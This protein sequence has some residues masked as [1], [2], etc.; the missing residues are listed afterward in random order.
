MEYGPVLPKEEMKQ[1]VWLKAYENRNVDIALESGFALHAQ[2]GKG[3]WT[4]PDAMQKMLTQKIAHPL[5]GATTAWVPSPTAATLHALHYHD[6]NV[7]KKL[8]EIRTRKIACVEDILTPPLLDRTLSREEVMQEVENNV[9]S[10][11]GYVVR[12]VEQGIGCSKVPDIHNIELMEDR[13]TL[14]I[15]SQHLANW[16]HHGIIDEKEFMEKLP[17]VAELAVGDACTGSNPRKI[18]PAQMEEL[19]KSC[20]FDKE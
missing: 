13:A 20:Y 14:R 16:L 19:L 8:E 17:K 15:S 3:M 2:I 1:S 4:M 12:W 18:T 7:F 5:A 6:V 10:I 9:Q 11:L